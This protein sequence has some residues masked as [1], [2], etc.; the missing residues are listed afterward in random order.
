[1]KSVLLAL[2]FLIG[3]CVF[4]QAQQDEK[5]GAKLPNITLKDLD[6]KSIN[7]S[8]FN[9]DG[10][11]FIINFWATWCKPCIKELNAINEV[12]EDW[13]EETG[14]KLI[15]ISIDDSR[16]AARV[17]PF[18]AGSNWDYEVYQDQNNDFKRAMG[19][20]NPPHTFIVNGNGEIVWQ[21]ASYVEGSEEHLIELVK[22]LIAGEDISKEK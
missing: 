2:T 17:R 18:V 16:S 22:K 7:T 9:N 1:M 8:E 4:V 6:G 21:G 13:Q 10:K 19:V 3:S 20:N 11:P 15:A 5:S 14:V 12:Y